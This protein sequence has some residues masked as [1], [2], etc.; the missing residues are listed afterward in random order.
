MLLLG[1]LFS[2]SL[3][4]S[5]LLAEDLV[6]EY[7]GNAGLEWRAFSEESRTGDQES[8]VSLSV[9]PE[10]Y[11]EWQGGKNSI[12]FTPFLR[13]DENDDER[14]H[15]DIREFEWIYVGS[16]WELRTGIR[17]VFWGVTEFQHLVDVI[18]QKDAVEDIDGEDKL[19]QPMVNLSLV[20]DWG[21]IDAFLLVGFR[22]RTF[23]GQEGRLRS[24]LLV[25]ADNARYESEDEEKHLDIV[26]RWSHSIGDYDFGAYW[27]RGTNRDPVLQVSNKSGGLVL[28]PFYEQMDQ[29]GLDVQATLDSWLWK[30]EAIYRDGK[31]SY[32]ASQ[33]GF[34]YTFYG[35][36]QTNSDLG[37]LLEYGWD[38]RGENGSSVF[39]ND[40]SVGARLTLNDIDSTELLAGFIHDLDYHSLSFQVEASRRF[41]NYWKVSIDGRFFSSD[42]MRDPLNSFD[43]DDHF[44][45][46]VERFF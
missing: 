16:N 20:R 31:E 13:L 29:W 22:E 38:E 40:I 27:F 37:L 35:L 46:R 7:S 23:P 41:G 42:D 1:S 32:W 9:E 14:S 6:F 39:Q 45:L 18:N 2:L 3:F 36:A 25:D 43:K 15:F 34:E 5:L 11:W 17:K 19:G 44:Q 12:T 4:S 10:F 26:L 33:A 8:N 24:R 30:L 28:V 21:I